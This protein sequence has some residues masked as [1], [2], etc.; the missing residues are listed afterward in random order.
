MKL[1]MEE[2]IIMR[3]DHFYSLFKKQF[4]DLIVAGFLNPKIIEENNR[5]IIFRCN[6]DNYETEE[7]AWYYGFDL[8]T[9][10]FYEA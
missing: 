6:Y 7:D 3:A 4:G 9:R 8:I 2:G 1:K 5:D 10:Q